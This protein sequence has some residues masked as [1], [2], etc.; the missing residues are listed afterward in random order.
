MLLRPS[1]KSLDLPRFFSRYFLVFPALLPMMMLGFSRVSQIL[2][3]MKVNPNA[4][5]G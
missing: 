2:L 4:A 3:V 1:R 5:G